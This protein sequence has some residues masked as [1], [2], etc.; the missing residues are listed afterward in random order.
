MPT[1]S[2]P[3]RRPATSSI[4]PPPNACTTTSIPAAA[5]STRKR[6]MSPSAAASPSPTRCC[7]GG[8]CWRRPWRERSGSHREPLPDQRQEEDRDV[9]GE[10][11]APED[12]SEPRPIADIGQHIGDAY[13]QEQHRQLVDQVLRGGAEFGEQHGGGEERKRLDA[14][15]VCA[16]RAGA[17]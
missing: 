1:P 3:S 13:D 6:P 10:A 5:R 2:A 9:D 15:L 11:D 8:D 7:G 17:D 16:E 14:V 4:R 12:G